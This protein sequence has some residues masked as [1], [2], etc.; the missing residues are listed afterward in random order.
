MNK[1]QNIIAEHTIIFTEA[2]PLDCRYCYSKVNENYMH[3]VEIDLEGMIERIER[4][5]KTD[6][7]N[8]KKTRILFSGGEPFLYWDTIRTIIEK[9]GTEISYK[10]NTS[11]VLLT[12]EILEYLSDFS[13]FFVLSCDGD[14]TL[15]NYLRPYRRNKYGVGYMKELRKIVPYILYYFPS[16][17]FRIIIGPRYID[18]LHE[19]YL[20]AERLGFKKFTFVLDFNSRPYIENSI[21]GRPWVNDDTDKLTIELRKICTEMLEGW[22]AGLDR[23]QVVEI[24]RVLGYFLRNETFDPYNFPCHVLN[25]RTLSTV[26]HND[27][28]GC[29]SKYFE[30]YKILE[31]ELINQYNQLGGKCPLE[32]ECPAF[33]YCANNSCPKNSL[34][35]YGK[36][37]HSEILEC[38]TNKAVYNA[39]IPMLEIANQC[40]NNSFYYKEWLQT[41]MKGGY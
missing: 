19:T 26:Y 9:F 38:A 2:C 15:T 37:F 16:T 14:E 8:G 22:R 34:D 29:M 17:P 6:I 27:D 39:A 36:F 32:P 33:E 41:L 31:E 10:F 40:C 11:G 3:G 1:T 23:P 24:N 25:G 28:C 18:K 35:Q 20:F 7:E 13:V 5:L 21:C 12:K 4:Y 30:N